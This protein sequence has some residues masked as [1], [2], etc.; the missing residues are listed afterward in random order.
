[1]PDVS[2]VMGVFNGAEHLAP[3]VESILTQDGVDLELVVIDDGSTDSSWAMLSGYAD[4]DSRVR[5]VRQ[6]NKGLTAALIAGCD[7]ARGSYIARQDADDVSLPGRLAR[8]VELLRCDPSL[9]FVSCWSEM[10]GPE[11]ELL[12]VHRPAPDRESATHNLM[13]KRSGPPGH[14]SVMMRAAS[15][16]AAG[17]YRS[18]FYYAQDADLW[19]RLGATGKLA[20]VPEVLYRY[21]VSERSISGNRQSEKDAYARLVD[22]CY[23]RR[24][25]GQDDSDAIKAFRPPRPGQRRK[26]SSAAT[27]YFVARC[28][29]ARDEAKGVDYLWRCVRRDPFHIRAWCALVCAWPRLVFR[30]KQAKGLPA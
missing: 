17:G 28:L 15:Y 11:G 25:A 26:R 2:V 23:A 19:L 16:R 12:H 7:M 29:L 5:L 8:Q 4:R 22:E 27:L 18:V 24:Q 1:M 30:S 10:V 14:G 21:A 13:V 20:Y 6:T 9:A 3:A